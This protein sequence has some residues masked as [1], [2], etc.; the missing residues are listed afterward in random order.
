MKRNQGEN[1]L[2]NKPTK[3]DIE[4]SDAHI[5]D[6]E[7]KYRFNSLPD[8]LAYENYLRIDNTNLSAKDVA[9]KTCEF[10]DLK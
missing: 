8:E 4:W 5:R 9:Q 7:K 1:R 6:V 10:F 2:A 3:R